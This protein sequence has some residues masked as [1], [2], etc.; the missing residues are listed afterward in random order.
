[1]KTVT[2]QIRL[3]PNEK[4]AFENAAILSGIALSGWVRERLR[5]AAVREL[6]QASRP[7]PFLSE[8]AH[9]RD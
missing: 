7:I 2:I 6:E 5:K 1:M 8:G 4:Q 3:T 9:G